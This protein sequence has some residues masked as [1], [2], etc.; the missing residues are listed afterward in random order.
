MSGA[1]KA[2]EMLIVLEKYEPVP[3]FRGKSNSTN[4]FVSVKEHQDE[5]QIAAPST[6]SSPKRAHGLGMISEAGAIDLSIVSISLTLLV[7]LTTL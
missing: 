5:I 7:G 2:D 1:L 3:V 6:D 4:S